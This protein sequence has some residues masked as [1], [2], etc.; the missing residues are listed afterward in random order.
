MQKQN[1]YIWNDV[2]IGKNAMI[3]KWVT[4]WTWAVIWAWAIVTKDIPPYAIA[5]GNPAKVKK[6]RFDAETI[7][8]LL[9]SERWNR[10]IEKIKKN[11]NLKFIIR[12]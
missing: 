8:K 2:W 11:Y 12:D 6:Y 4:I 1:L 7:Q 10:D 9:E 5:V 3:I